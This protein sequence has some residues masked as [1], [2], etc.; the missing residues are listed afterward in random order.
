MP[1]RGGA[2]TVGRGLCTREEGPPQQ[3]REGTSI[4][5][6]GGASIPG[7]GQGLHSRGEGSL[8]QEGAGLPQQGGSGV[9]TL[10]GRG[11]QVRGW[12]LHTRK[13]KGLHSREG[14]EGPLY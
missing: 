3:G 11:C 7:K 5:E 13:G 2:S 14:L 1:E 4:L 9:S 12:G 8:Y 6:R 10:E